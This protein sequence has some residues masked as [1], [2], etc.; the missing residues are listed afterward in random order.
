MESFSLIVWPIFLPIFNFHSNSSIYNK[1]EH[2]P[3]IWKWHSV[4][5]KVYNLKV[6]S[7]RLS[8]I[9][10][11]CTSIRILST[12]VTLNASIFARQVVWQDHLYVIVISRLHSNSRLK[13]SQKTN[14]YISM[15]FV[16]QLDNYWQN[17]S[18]KYRA[19]TEKIVSRVESVQTE[20]V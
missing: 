4:Y 10:E 13:L 7:Y 12:N 8:G 18:T 9:V 16:A 1:N 19:N 3:Q 5:L 15:I 6:I 20:S 11:L 14:N 17:I 2:L